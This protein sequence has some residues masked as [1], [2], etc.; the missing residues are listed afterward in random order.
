MKTHIRLTLKEEVGYLTFYTD[1][2]DKPPAFDLEVLEE[3]S[4]CLQTIH[5]EMEK[6]RALIINSDSTKFFSVGAHYKALSEITKNTITEWVMRWNETFDLLEGLP[7]PTLSHVNGY[8]LGGGLEFLLRCDLIIATT[9]SHFGVPEVKLGFVPASGGSYRLPKRVG[10]AKAKELFFSGKI[11]D[12]QEAYKIGLIDF[13]GSETETNKYIKNFL[14]DI[15]QNSRFA[16]AMIKKAMCDC[17]LADIK[18][19]CH[20][21]IINSRAC[22]LS[23]DAQQR[24]E[25]FLSKKKEKK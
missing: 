6:Y 7:V 9:N 1:E 22:L 15:L 18:Q 5:N 20:E 23:G 16:I 4:V 24:L 2:P 19:Y 3:L 21:D 8:A 17:T 13:I 14:S 12:A 11:I 25:N 10:I